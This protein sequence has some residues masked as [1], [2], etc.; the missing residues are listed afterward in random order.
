MALTSVNTSIR[1]PAKLY[2][3]LQKA[4][5]KKKETEIKKVNQNS[6]MVDAIEK[7]VKQILS[8]E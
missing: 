7:E 8:Q 6:V 3:L 1:L 4:V 2:K 5:E